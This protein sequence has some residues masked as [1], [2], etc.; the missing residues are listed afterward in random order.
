MYVRMC[1]CIISSVHNLKNVIV[2]SLGTPFCTNITSVEGGQVTKPNSICDNDAALK[3]CS[4][5]VKVELT[6]EV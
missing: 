2:L 6:K 5:A 3:Y 4:C 1:V